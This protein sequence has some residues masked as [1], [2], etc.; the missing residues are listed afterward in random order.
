MKSE[1]SDGAE[2]V[3][4]RH[5][6]KPPAPCTS[7]M[8]EGRDRKE[9]GRQGPEGRGGSPAYPRETFLGQAALEHLSPGE[10]GRKWPALLK[11]RQGLA[12]CSRLTAGSCGHG[13]GWA[14]APG[15][16]AS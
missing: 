11:G 2:V 6:F 15:H 13:Q 1:G 8:A 12:W 5:S 3:S 9:G 4:R 14:L 7:E 10:R 16:L